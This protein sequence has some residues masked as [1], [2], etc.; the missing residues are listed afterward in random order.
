MT[1]TTA[2]KGEQ[3]CR[4]AFEQW[5]L[6]TIGTIPIFDRDSG[7]YFDS[8]VQQNWR[9]WK[10]AWN[11]RPTCEQQ[12]TTNEGQNGLTEI[13][14]L[15]DAYGDQRIMASRGRADECDVEESRAELREAIARH[16]SSKQATRLGNAT[17][18]D[19]NDVAFPKGFMPVDAPDDHIEETFG[20]V[21]AGEGVDY[22]A[23][24]FATTGKLSSSAPTEV[25]EAFKAGYA[26]ATDHT[27]EAVREL[28]EGLRKERDLR[29][30][31][32][33]PEC[34]KVHWESMRE[35]RRSAYET[36]DALLAKYAPSQ[37]GGNRG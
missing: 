29:I 22:R 2:D 16:L 26:T 17:M 30:L 23:L 28:V 15:V 6:T 13:L 20:M 24:F 36:T 21:P 14:R 1:T 27:A 9:S 12:R 18:Y 25:F 33:S 34:G 19:Q 7:R 10:T 31:G 4:E 8:N 32:Q 35:M 37:E 5:L 3:E 11:R